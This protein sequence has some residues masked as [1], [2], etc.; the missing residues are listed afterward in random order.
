[1][2]R[3]THQILAA[4][5]VAAQVVIPLRAFAQEENFDSMFEED[6]GEQGANGQNQVPPPTPDFNG[7]ANPFDASGNP[8]AAT[9]TQNPNAAAAAAEAG[10]AENPNFQPP[11]AAGR[12]SGKG[13]KSKPL[14]SAKKDAAKPP[15]ST[16]GPED[17][18]NAN[19]P[20]LIES[21]DYP[22][23]DISDV[24]KAIS[25][26]TGKNFI[27][28]PSVRGK[29]TIMAPTQ[30]TVAEAYKAFLSALAINGFTVVPSG[31]FLKI[32]PTR[33]AARSN[34]ET[35]SG[36]YYPNSD[37]MITRIVKLKH[38]SADEVNKNLRFLPTKDGEMNPYTPTNS[39][40][41]TDYGSNIDRIMKILNELDQPGFE[42]QMIVMPVK[43]AKAKDMADLIMQIINKE[44][45]ASGATNGFT[46]GIPRF[47]RTP[48]TSRNGMPEELSL[49]AP[50]DRTNSIIVVG[51][52]TGVLKIRMLLN[53][54]DYKLDPTENGGVYVY[55]VKYGDAEKISTTLQGVT[56]GTAGGGAASSPAAN[57]FGGLKPFVPP[58]EQHSIFGG[59]VKI[60]PDKANNSLVISASKQDYQ[61]VLSLLAKIDIPRDQVY[62]ETYIVEMNSNRLKQVQFNIAKYTELKDAN[63]N[64]I[65]G[66]PIG[67]IGSSPSTLASLLAG[68]A[69]GAILGFGSGKTL[70]VGGSPATT[71]T[72]TTGTTTP[73]AGTPIPSLLALINFLV[74]TA[75][76]NVL[77]TPQILALDNEESEIEVGQKVATGV[78]TTTA[79]SAQTTS[80]PTYEDATIK[81]N[82]TPYI[83][84]DSEDVRMKLTQTL[85]QPSGSAATV[86]NTINL[87]ERSI[88]TN[89]VVA[90][91]DTA[92]LGGLLKDQQIIQEQK[93][94]L[95]GDIPILGF[96]FRSSQVQTQKVN[97]M[98]FLSPHIIRNSQD[99]HKLLNAKR[100]ERIQWIKR[101][102]DGRDPFGETVSSLPMRGSADV[103]STARKPQ[104]IEKL[105]Q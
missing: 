28:D 80:S 10:G 63:G 91:G 64:S 90:N 57:S 17:I 96:L 99:H 69:N 59:D 20:D 60:N 26:L 92:V 100:N 21:F 48:G 88:K 105:R 67:F 4:A 62:V 18:T 49:V 32:V 16:A 41:I 75:D 79:A 73:T 34:I 103:P 25:E 8:N 36:A 86:A 31:K 45:K 85:K 6:A 84:P 71:T 19:Y 51:N 24:V 95:L 1:M 56:A 78:T 39:L 27:V 72:G 94:P 83:S 5:L 93:V 54:L 98:V 7:G 9:G 74:T 81:L 14:S 53:K 102:N 52:K 70:T 43:N 58:S 37:V 104:S 13:G 87:D 82:I 46:A 42:E 50:D 66:P 30:I 33:T 40:I 11:A 65:A 55:Y 12:R 35:Y 47:P 22:N 97:L 77:S 68:T 2:K 23:A 76:T 89:I 38:I 44:P 101:N 29:I 61:I 3:F 15:L